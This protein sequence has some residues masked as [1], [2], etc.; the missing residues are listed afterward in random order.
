MNAFFSQ[1]ILGGA[2]KA[3]IDR[4]PLQA[5]EAKEKI[6]AEQY[7]QLLEEFELLEMA[8]NPFDT[9][10]FSRRQSHPCLFCLRPDQFWR[11]A[12]FRCLYP[13]C[14]L[15]SRAHGQSSSTGQRLKSIR[16]PP[17]LAAMYLNSRPIW[18]DAIATAWPLSGFAPEDLSA[19]WSSSTIA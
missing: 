9:R 12:F 1:N 10:R 14:P 6:G 16:S 3:D 7:N 5:Q 4:F 17:L 19:I 8:G 13:S 2:Q 18:T 11:R 15:P